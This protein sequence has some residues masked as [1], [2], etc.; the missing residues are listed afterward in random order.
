MSVS[1]VPAFTGRKLSLFEDPFPDIHELEEPMSDFEETMEPELESFL[2]GSRGSGLDL[3]PVIIEMLRIEALITTAAHF[4]AFVTTSVEDIIKIFGFKRPYI[5]SHYFVKIIGL[6]TYFDPLDKTKMLIVNDAGAFDPTQDFD[7]DA[8]IN[9]LRRISRALT[10]EFYQAC[11][12]AALKAK[13]VQDYVSSISPARAKLGV[14]RVTPV[15][16]TQKPSPPV[17]PGVT[18]RKSPGTGGD[19]ASRRKSKSRLKPARRILV[20]PPPGTPVRKMFLEFDD[21]ED[22]VDETG[23]DVDEGS[24]GGAPITPEQFLARLT[25]FEPK[26]KLLSRTPLSSKT[27]WDDTL[28]NAPD[29]KSLFEGHMTQ[30]GLSYMFYP[31]NSDYYA[32]HGIEAFVNKFGTIYNITEEQMNHDLNFVY[33]ALKSAL[34]KSRGTAMVNQFSST[35]DGLMVWRAWL[36][37]YDN[38]GDE[39]T[40]RWRYEAAVQVQYTPKFPGGLATYIQSIENAYIELESLGQHFPDETK[41]RTLLRTSMH[42][43][44]KE[45]ISHCEDRKYSFQESCDYLTGRGKTDDYVADLT[46]QRRVKVSNQN[47]LTPYEEDTMRIVQAVFNARGVPSPY[48]VPKD[49]WTRLQ[50]PT[51]EE[52]SAARRLLDLEKKGT[53][54]TKPDAKP[55][56]KFD[57][58]AP[59]E[60]PKQYPKPSHTANAAATIH[61]KDSVPKDDNTSSDSDPDGPDLAAITK[62]LAAYRHAN[63]S[64]KSLRI[65][66]M[67]YYR[68]FS[69]YNKRDPN[70]GTVVSD[71]GADTWV[72]GLQWKIEEVYTHRVANLVGF[73]PK[74]AKKF[75]LSIGC[76]VAMVDLADG[77]SFMLR[78]HEGII[79]PDA[80][81]TLMSEFQTREAGCAI[82]SVAKKHKHIDGKPGNQAFV[83]RKDVWIPFELMGGLMT[84]TIRTPTSEEYEEW[85]DKAI[86]VTNSQPWNPSTHS[87]DKWKVVRAF[88]ASNIPDEPRIDASDDAVE[89][90]QE[91]ESD[92]D[93]F[94]EANASIQT[95]NATEA[96][97][98]I[99]EE[100]EDPDLDDLHY[101]DPSDDF[102]SAAQQ[103]RAFH[104][105]LNYDAMSNMDEPTEFL[106]DHAVEGLLSSF[107]NDELIG[108][109]RGFDSFAFAVQTAHKFNRMEL[110]DVQPYFGYRPLH[111]IQKTL[112]K[113]TQLATTLWRY[114]MRRH[115]KSRFPYLN[116]T[117][118]A[119]V[120]STD[121]LFSSVRAFGGATCAQVF[122]GLRSHVINV[123]GQRKESD[124]YDSYRD[125]MRDEGIPS[126]L[127]RDLARTEKSQKVTELNREYLVEDQWSEAY[128][129]QQNPVESQAIK[130]LKEHNEILL[131]RSGAPPEAWLHSLI[132]LAQIH[133]ICSDETLD[134]AIPLSIRRGITLDISAWLLYMF[135]APL[136]YLDAEESFPSSK[137]KPGHWLGVAEHIG[138]ALTFWIWPVDG[139]EPIARSVVRP[140]DS[141]FPNKRLTFEDDKK[142]DVKPDVTADSDSDDKSDEDNKPFLDDPGHTPPDRPSDRTL[143]ALE[144]IHRSRRDAKKKQKR[145]A[146]RRRPQVPLVLST[147]GPPTVD[148]L[149]DADQDLPPQL[150]PNVN[151]ESSELTSPMNVGGDKVDSNV[152]SN[153]SKL[154]PAKESEKETSGEPPVSADSGEPPVSADSGES[155]VS[156]ALGETPVSADSGET[157][158]AALSGEQGRQRRQRKPVER[159]NLNTR[160]FPVATA[161]RHE[162]W[163][164]L[165]VAG[166]LLFFFNF[167]GVDAMDLPDVNDSLPEP[168]SVPGIEPVMEGPAYST[169]ATHR[170]LHYIQMCDHFENLNNEDPEDRDWIP[171]KVLDHRIGKCR[172][173]TSDGQQTKSRHL[174]VKVEWMNG[175]TS[176]VQEAAVRLED[177][178]VLVQYAVDRGL[179]K[180]GDFK[181]IKEYTKDPDRIV[182]MSQ[183][184]K[185]KQ[186]GPQFKFGIEVARSPKHAL[187]LDRIN[188]NSLWKDAMDKELNQINSYETFRAI[189]D[190]AK[191]SKDYQR[192]PYHIVFDVKFDL[193]RK[194]RLVAGGN[195]TE[196]PKEDIYSGVVG[197]DTIRMGFTVAAMN[198]LQ[199]VA[200]D[201]GNAFLYGKTKEKV[202]IIAGPEF[203]SDQGKRLIVDKGLYGLKT[204]AARF[205]E[206]L[207]AK[208]RRMGFKPT[209]AD[210]DFWIRDCKDHYEY[211]ATYVDD[212][213]AYSRDPMKIIEEVK[214]DYVLK[215]I[216][217]PVYYLGGNI[218]QLD[219]QWQKQGINT[220]LSAETYIH[221]VT[222]KLEEMLGVREFA[223]FKSPM[224]D[225]Y[226]PELDDTPILDSTEASKFRAMVGS[227]NWVITLGRFDIA[228]ATSALSRFSMQPRVGHLKAMRRVFGYLKSHA[229]GCI[230]IDPNYRDWSQYESEDFDNW[231]EFY[232]DAEEDDK[233]PKMPQPKGTAAR[234]TVYVD[235]DHA[236]DQLTRR[237]VTGIVLLVNNTPVKWVSKR[238]KTVE[239]STYGSEL[240]AARIATDL[241]IE[242]RYTLRMLGVPVDGPALLLGDN[243][244][245]ILN[246]TVPSSILRKKHNAVAY[247][248]IREAVAGGIMRFVHI[249]TETNYADFLTKPLPTNK[250]WQ[251]VKPLLFRTPVSFGQ[252]RADDIVSEI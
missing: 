188:G 201:I 30:V 170:Q 27:T 183:A 246:T 29:F 134:Y 34:R 181:W 4:L 50:E 76:G 207:S 206:H 198:D 192:I 22:D 164:G 217:T 65:A 144:R 16:P 57:D 113:T 209:N 129:Q 10:S 79:N 112:E 74:D 145:R 78:C 139:S 167:L 64:T 245:V 210:T 169:A 186:H 69:G 191:L 2:T 82:D 126:G 197:M 84:Y 234:I 249:D 147:D 32:L 179:E 154:D 156:N 185:A 42:E 115:F 14:P 94:L 190:G 180:H 13:Q 133:N 176:W 72:L 151:V 80:D 219:E 40:E 116:R 18:F 152:D 227:A 85:A 121:T 165:F 41:L 143:T 153:V 247:H 119:E 232:P 38:H 55:E 157:P 106:R 233:P 204:S 136:Y 8:Y 142:P 238:Q 132:Y 195:W 226:H 125:F 135:W 104:L 161:S 251:L 20:T 86:E 178:I 58:K 43:D 148:V 141:S 83:P 214:K 37:R 218:K 71:A 28:E 166:A 5:F 70:K 224:S 63:V 237:S 174:R 93:V 127:R 252:M 149:T 49:L 158:V 242:Y 1:D 12:T 240:V 130:Y 59:T 53:E 223:S 182:A 200:A 3:P 131:D 243:K 155:P 230:V 248:R 107:D 51:R 54:Q 205:H 36:D 99:G 184:M 140:A 11:A 56:V 100:A 81:L 229:Q 228:Y 159:L 244:S 105:T 220:A 89:V 173:V 6:R 24:T 213:L 23:S 202:Y 225:A 162:V 193:R 108:H 19:P 221:N 33:G 122:Y 168:D 101:F 146:Q 87:D 216:G 68:I 98:Y 62:L 111:I 75:G 25:K 46:A 235:A 211:V 199:V 92:D 236:H 52:Y 91:Q 196:S 117:R 61:P 239:T 120:I 250:Y 96:E 7:A 45:W 123:Y 118:L 9:H 160:S 66:H 114:P 17:P 189:D 109:N 194:A 128:N 21:D 203:G 97:W 171:H 95:A 177:P 150:R 103:G 212:I 88:L 208:L 175:T 73:D 15:L 60:I 35:N 137:E 138:D 47:D 215:G 124:F 44:T 39:R 172:R 67:E 163:K 222:K 48:S 187:E 110:E 102:S 31:P 231:K 26:T 90:I 77:R 241:I